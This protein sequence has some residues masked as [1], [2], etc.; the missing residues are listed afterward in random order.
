MS[1]HDS[2]P[3]CSR[4]SVF[5]EHPAVR[6]LINYLSSE[7]LNV[8]RKNRKSQASNDDVFLHCHFL[9]LVIPHTTPFKTHS[10]CQ[11]QGTVPRS[12]DTFSSDTVEKIVMVFFINLLAKVEVL[13]CKFLLN[14]SVCLWQP[15]F[16]DSCF[17]FFWFVLFFCFLV[18]Q[19]K[20]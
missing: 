10:K 19:L 7:L 11:E 5:T 13:F 20:A 14:A 1:L 15:D 6:I 16:Q 12:P 3:C 2:N 9:F 18:R 17:L 8:Q 4:S